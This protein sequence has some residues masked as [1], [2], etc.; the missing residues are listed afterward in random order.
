M[1]IKSPLGEEI[2]IS[3][4]LP[5]ITSVLIL[6]GLSKAF[7]FK[8]NSFLTALLIG[9]FYVIINF[10]IRLNSLLFNLTDIQKPFMNIL[11]GTVSTIVLIIL[12]VNIYKTNWW[13]TIVCWLFVFYGKFMLI[14][15]VMLMMMLFIPGFSESDSA[16]IAKPGITDF[17]IGD[18]GI[19]IGNNHFRVFR[20]E[21]VHSTDI[22]AINLDSSIAF[23]SRVENVSMDLKCTSQDGKIVV[24]SLKD[25]TGMYEFELNTK[26]DLGIDT[27]KKGY[28]FFDCDQVCTKEKTTFN[29]RNL[30]NKEGQ[31]VTV[32]EIAEMNTGKLS[33][34]RVLYV[35]KEKPIGINIDFALKGES[36]TTLDCEI[37]ITSEN[38][39]QTMKK[40]FIV[41]YIVD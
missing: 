12:L 8:K 26:N 21:V 27:F 18:K 2:F 4:L 38:P 28:A 34:T 32:S 31:Y 14:G 39:P 25:N 29:L 35:E 16:P 6:W 37:A 23:S 13:K 11:G 7:K 33:G 5:L 1:W 41:E 19:E 20:S 17:S 22:F 3:L 30:I 40:S 15:I 9:S 36:S 10:L 24:T